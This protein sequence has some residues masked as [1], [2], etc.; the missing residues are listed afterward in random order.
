MGPA[1]L[2]VRH[3]LEAP[4]EERLRAAVAHAG[5][6]APACTA[7]VPAALEALV[8][9]DDGP[10][11]ADHVRA[12]ADVDQVLEM[13]RQRSVYQ[14]KE[15]DPT[16]WVVPRLP[17]RAKAAL[18]EL[19]FD[20]YGDGD[21]NRLHA[22]LFARG[23]GVRRPALGVRRVRRRRT[24]GPSSSTTRCRCSA[25]TGGCGVRR[26]ATSRPSR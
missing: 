10:S 26:W 23:H 17:V 14:L 5:T 12:R 18:V 3:D 11:L 7:D 13:L 6:P 15:A 25:C 19:Q 8:A 9:A 24:A 2:A 1:V 21:P 4:L 20:E 16:T 22:H